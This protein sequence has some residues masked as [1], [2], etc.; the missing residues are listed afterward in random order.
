MTLQQ[1]FAQKSNI[2]KLPAWGAS[3]EVTGIAG[4]VIVFGIFFV[5]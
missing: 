5:A 1:K 2:T 3:G 4:V